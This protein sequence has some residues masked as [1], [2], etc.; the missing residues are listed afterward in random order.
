MEM[1]TTNLNKY[2]LAVLGSLL[3]TMALGVISSA[4]FAAHKPIK[5]GYDLPVPKEEASAAGAPKEAPEE[6]LPVLLAHAD[7]AKGQSDTKACQAC[8]NFE[9]GAG[10]KV[11]PPLWG[12]V[13]RPMA[14]IPG[15]AYSDALKAMGK[16]W[17]Y[18]EIFKFIKEPKAD[19]AGTKMAYPGEKDPA[20][21]A[22]IL[23]YLQTLSDAPVPFPK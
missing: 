7:A 13:D 3:A 9:K 4:I 2:A 21:R 12:V 6:P 15:F 14:S 19:V 20:K 11:G 23:A 16:T 22:D 10:P 1:E 8:H 17:T 5:P 18:E